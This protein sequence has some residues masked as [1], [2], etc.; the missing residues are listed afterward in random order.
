MSKGHSFFDFEMS[1]TIRCSI[2]IQHVKSNLTM[3]YAYTA[4]RISYYT[5]EITDI[6]AAKLCQAVRALRGSPGVLGPT[7]RCSAY[8][9]TP[10]VCPT[11]KSTGL[12]QESGP[13]WYVYIIYDPMYYMCL[14]TVCCGRTAD[15]RDYCWLVVHELLVVQLRLPAVTSNLR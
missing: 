1:F 11:P 9:T 7:S 3:M 15:A 8:P 4:Y 14:Y 5:P 12:P 13:V 10:P 6:R 2:F